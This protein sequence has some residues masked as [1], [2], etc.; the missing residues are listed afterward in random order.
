[1]NNENDQWLEKALKEESY[2]ADEGFSS[3]ILKQMENEHLKKM[4]S[5]KTILTISYIISFVFLALLAPWAAIAEKS[6]LLLVQFSSIN[7]DAS[8]PITALSIVFVTVFTTY[9]LLQESDH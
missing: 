2:I 7:S 4:R 6:N 9:V 5:R 1:M 8:L 3:N